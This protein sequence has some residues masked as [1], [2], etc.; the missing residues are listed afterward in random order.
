MSKPKIAYTCTDCGAQS[1]KWSGQCGDCGAWNSLT[2]VVMTAKSDRRPQFKGYAGAEMT[3]EV[4]ELSAISATDT[5]RIS[6]QIQ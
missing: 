2:E 1:P 5:M 3:Q 6:T 4:Q